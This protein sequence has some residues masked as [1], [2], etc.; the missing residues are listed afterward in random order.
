[1]LARAGTDLIKDFAYLSVSTIRCLE[2]ANILTAQ[3]LVRKSE[4]D[5]LK[6][7]G[8]RKTRLNELKQIMAIKGLYLLGSRDW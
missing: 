4:D 6:I 1:M 3:D 8:F 7:P 5:L 2:S